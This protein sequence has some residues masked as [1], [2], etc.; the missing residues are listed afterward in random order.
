MPVICSEP[1]FAGLFSD[2]G[3]SMRESHSEQNGLIH[4]FVLDGSGG[5]RQIGYQALPTLQLNGA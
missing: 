1:G 4:A 3:T 5:A 2:D